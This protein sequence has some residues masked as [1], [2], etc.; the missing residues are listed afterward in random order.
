MVSLTETEK[1]GI[2]IVALIRE[3]ML[4]TFK[5]SVCS[6]DMAVQRNCDMEDDFP[7]SVY[8]HPLV[9][10]FYV[11]PMRMI[12]LSVYEWLDEFDYYEKS[13][14]NTAPSYK[15]V[16]PRFW[17]ATKYYEQFKFELRQYNEKHKPKESD[18]NLSKMAGL[19]KKGD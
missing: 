12:S 11:C 2:K 16:S 7:T 14:W 13:Q 8:A 19:F 3:G 9:G 4:D 1:I 5:C 10:E 6:S 15:E 18:D 17:L